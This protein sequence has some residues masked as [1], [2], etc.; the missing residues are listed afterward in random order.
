MARR[1]ERRRSRCNTVPIEKG[2]ETLFKHWVGVVWKKEDKQ[3]GV[4]TEP[5]TL[6]SRNGLRSRA[7]LDQHRITY[8][9]K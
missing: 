6:P 9:S 5:S 8:V 1:R 7:D 4:P 2:T 3:S